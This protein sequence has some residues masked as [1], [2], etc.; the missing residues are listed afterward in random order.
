MENAPVMEAAALKI[1]VV[2]LMVNAMQNA[3]AGSN[4]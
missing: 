4:S 1:T 2:V 3:I